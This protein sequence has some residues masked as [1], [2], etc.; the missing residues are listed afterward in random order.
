MIAI[1]H[2][3]RPERPRIFVSIAAYRDP[4]CQHTVKDLFENA[5]HPERI[6]AGIV[7]QGDKER[8]RHCFEVPAP[9]PN[10]VRL[11]EVDWRE[12]K[13]VC[14]ARAQKEQLW[15][16]EEYLFQIDSHMRFEP[17]WDEALIGMQRAC[18]SPK[19]VLSGGLHAAAPHSV[20]RYA[21]AGAERV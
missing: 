2:E 6:F 14:W 12:S 4:E 3:G 19:A 20:S 18:P 7:W 15:H 17:G 8:D 21:P 5:K 1:A 13:G 10:Q 9:R 16:G 11:I